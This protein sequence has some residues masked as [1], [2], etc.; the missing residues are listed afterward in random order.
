ME[1]GDIIILYLHSPKERIWGQL[2]SLTNFGLVIKGLDINS[3][4]DWC[5]QV[6]RKETGIGLT[7]VFYPTYRIEKIIMD[8]EVSGMQALRDRFRELSGI[9]LES[10]LEEL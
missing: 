10:Y 7:T 9:S 3:F 6:A 1:P 5:R 4:D 2:K 8:E